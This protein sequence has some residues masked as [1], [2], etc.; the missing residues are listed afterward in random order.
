MANKK[1]FTD[2]SL[3]TLVSEIMTYTDEA[4]SAKVDKITGKGLSTNDYTSAEKTKL[5]GIETGA[6]VNTITGVK[7]DSES[8]YRTGNVNITKANIGLGNVDNTADSAKRVSYAESAGSATSATSAGS[9]TKATQDASGNVITSTYE[10][11][12]DASAKLASANEYTDDKIALLMENSSPAVDSIMELASAMKENADVVDALEQAIGN[13]ADAEH[14]HD[15]IYY[16]ETEID[17][18]ISDLN[19]AI[20]GKAPS[21][22]S[23]AIS[24]VT[25]LQTTLDEIA[26]DPSVFYVEVG[27]TSF[28]EIDAAYNA[29]K[30]LVG[31]DDN[32]ILYRMNT[33][34]PNE[35]Y[36]FEHIEV[37]TPVTVTYHYCSNEDGGYWGSYERASGV[38]SHAST[39]AADGSDPITPAAI[40][41]PTIGEMNA[42]IDAKQAIITG[43]ASTIT[44]SNLTESRALVSDGSGKVAVSP[45]TSTEI[46]YLGGVK[47]NIQEQLD[48]KATS[49]N[50]V[51]GSTR[52]SLRTVGAEAENEEYAMGWYS[53]AEG[54]A[55]TS[56]GNFSHAEG[57]NTAANGGGSHAEGAATIANGEGSHAEGD[58]TIANGEYSHAEGSGTIADGNYQH[59]QGKYNIADTTSA[60]IVGNGN[61]LTKS[62]AHT[63]DWEG[64]AWFS[65]DVYVGSTSGTNK[66]AGSKKL[67]TITIREW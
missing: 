10:T 54:Y 12:T 58:Y 5:S 66:D 52:G 1:Y 17:S 56:K 3:S 64:N 50:L 13:K 23:H 62:N 33:A 49:T 8:S 51:N 63:L 29:G 30:H 24:D 43:G 55:T 19:S 40:G 45:V 32:T 60:H 7:G 37:T 53:Y 11:K 44:D 18:K 34:L 67:A 46:G 31:I 41:A 4:T 35:T 22:H 59:V 21:T 39:H 16:T 6:Q 15:D 27:K 47:S 20:N 48:N 2:E 28:A 9:A 42:L 61:S 36:R 38:E 25:N 65:G 14:S 57:G 26:S